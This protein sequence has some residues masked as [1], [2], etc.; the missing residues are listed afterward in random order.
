M[1]SDQVICCKN[2]EIRGNTGFSQGCVIHP[3][4]S[5]ITDGA[6]IIFGEFNIIEERVHFVNTD[7]AGC[8]S[9]VP[10]Q[11]GTYNQFEVG[12]TIEHCRIGSFNVFE[13]RCH[14]EPDVSI[15]NC[16][17]VVAGV[18]VPSGTQIPDSTIVYGPNQ[19]RANILNEDFFKQNIRGLFEVL[20]KCIPK[21]NALRQSQR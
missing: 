20:K 4:S 18:R 2:I 10:L 17:I 1:S 8:P 13:H 7:K 3:N 12:A 15:G 5:I 9:H 6:P 19:F 16:C 11:V 21:Y 14:I